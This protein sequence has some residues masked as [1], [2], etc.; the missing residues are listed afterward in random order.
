MIV[1][2]HVLALHALSQGVIKSLRY[3]E[4][5][6]YLKDDSTRTGYRRMKY[7]PLSTRGRAAVTLGGELRYQYQFFQNEEWGDVEE[8]NNGFFFLRN[9]FHADLRFSDNFR[10]FGQVKS[11]FMI[12]RP[13]PPRAIDENR[14][15]VHQFFVEGKWK[16]LHARLGRQELM[17]GSQRLI[18]VREGPN[19]R[20]TFD[21][22]KFFTQRRNAKFD[23][24]VAWPVVDRP[25]IVDDRFN[26]NTTLWGAYLMHSNVHLI[27]NA[28]IYYLGLRTTAGRFDEGTGTEIRHSFGTR[29]WG[30]TANWTYD[31][32]AVLQTGSFAGKRILAYTVSSNISYRIA[33]KKLAP[34]LGLKTELI[35][36]D[37][38]RGDDRLQTFNPLFPR[39]AYF[40]LAALIGPSNL[41]D[42]HPSVELT[43]TRNLV[44]AVDYDVFWRY[45]RQ[46]GIYGP[47]ARPIYGS[48]GTQAK[49][50]GDQLGTSITFE[51]SG[52][53]NM[54]L[55]STWFNTGPYLKEAGAGKDIFFHA[56]TI[57]LKY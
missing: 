53:F 27:R 15:D 56:F 38:V 42:I 40:G 17:Y 39:G 48:E 50:I 37:L 13:Q 19:N 18:S 21:G 8:D 29:W 46:D 3:D 35:S 33:A 41:I 55:E 44:W 47:N 23:V 52:N 36:G 16:Q 26:Q 14:F 32:E 34:A 5:F 11:N 22:L 54:V 57:Q 10:V 6:S 24:F 12:D 28:D 31:Q 4:D 7:I 25:G 9:L 20:Q 1:F 30:K 2:Y 43:L 49:Y 45:S 51:P